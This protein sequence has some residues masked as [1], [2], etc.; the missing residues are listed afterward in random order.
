[1]AQRELTLVKKEFHELIKILFL[2]LGKWQLT[3][4]IQIAKN[5]QTCLESNIAYAY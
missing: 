1:M 2:K 5:I 4:I 3:K